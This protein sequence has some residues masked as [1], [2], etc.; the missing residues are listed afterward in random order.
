MG[1]Y[2]KIFQYLLQDSKFA[3]VLRLLTLRREIAYETNF[4][5]FC[6]FLPNSRN[7]ILVKNPPVAN[8]RN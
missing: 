6:E 1:L 4:C 2:N 7:Q 3:K 8:S 5:D